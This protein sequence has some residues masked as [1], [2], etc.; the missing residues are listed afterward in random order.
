MT[1][2]IATEAK[3]ATFSAAY[4]DHKREIARAAAD[5]RGKMQSRVAAIQA[6]ATDMEND[7]ETFTAADVAEMRG[8]L[9]ILQTEVQSVYDYVSAL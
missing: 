7:P 8:L 2:S 6:N 3:R 9:T 4:N 1:M 5:I